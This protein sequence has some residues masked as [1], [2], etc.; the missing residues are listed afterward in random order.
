MGKEKTGGDG[1]YNQPDKNMIRML[2]S[3]V[4]AY[5]II[6]IE[7]NIARFHITKCI[8]HHCISFRKPAQSLCLPMVEG[9]LNRYSQISFVVM[10]GSS[11]QRG[12][13]TAM[14]IVYIRVQCSDTFSEV[15]ADEAE[16][17]ELTIESIV[18]AALLEVFDT[19]LVDNVTVHRPQ[20]RNNGNEEQSSVG[21]ESARR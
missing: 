8:D 12:K 2:F 14:C 15:F 7:G 9:I 1:L 4:S 19:V 11:L 5:G 18:G 10:S 6:L 20:E 3:F 21:C 17:T 13:E 16:Q